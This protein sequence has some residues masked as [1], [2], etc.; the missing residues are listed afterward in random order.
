MSASLEIEFLG[1]GTSTGVPVIGCSCAVCLSDD[2]GNNRLRSSVLIRCGETRLLVDTSPDL[3]QQAFRSGLTAI[4]AVLYTH[5]HLDHVAGFD[6]LRAFCWSR[7]EPLPLYAGPETMAGLKQMFGWAFTNSYIGYVRP[8]PHIVTEPFQVGALRVTPV[9]VRH[10][11]VEALGYIFESPDGARLGYIPDVKEVPEASLVLLEG[12]DLLVVDGL[13]KR[14]HETHFSL[15]EAFA[16]FA[17]V[18][19]GQ[20]YL[21]HM[22]HE[23]DYSSARK[24]LPDKVDLAFDGLVLTVTPTKDNT[25]LLL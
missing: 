8:D 24:E 25:P 12:L 3:R 10:G 11:Q 16:L 4:D 6:E 23:I 1:T 5:I 9:P 2:P 17:R 21:T 13:R 15:D 20:G 7:Q 18:S 19:P 14:G 22:S